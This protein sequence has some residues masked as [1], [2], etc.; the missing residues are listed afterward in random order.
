M[1]SR[2]ARLQVEDGGR[3][4]FVGNVQGTQI[5]AIGWEMSDRVSIGGWQMDTEPM[6]ISYRLF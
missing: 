1:E 6:E 3:H 2:A 4:H 5:Y